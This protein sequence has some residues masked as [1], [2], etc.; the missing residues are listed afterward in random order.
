MNYTSAE[1]IRLAILAAADYAAACTGPTIRGLNGEKNLRG[2]SI[3]EVA[4]NNDISVDEA[5]Q[6][7]VDLASASWDELGE[8]WQRVNLDSAEGMIEL[9]D[10][11]G[12]PSVIASADLDNPEVQLKL[13][14]LLHAA[15]LQQSSNSWA[16]GGDLDKPY[17]ELPETE[18]AKD[19]QQLRSLQKWLSETN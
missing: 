17:S 5:K 18:Q 2:K 16:L 11:L 13:G 19:L 8:H 1:I 7:T 14:T 9:M 3:E 12:G 4:A 15:W 10:A 6:L